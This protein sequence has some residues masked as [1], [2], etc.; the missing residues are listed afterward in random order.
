LFITLG[1][2]LLALRRPQQELVLAYPLLERQ[3]LAFQVLQV[4]V[5]ELVFPVLVRLALRRPQQELVL[6]Y[7]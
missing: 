7:P 5:L 6:A 3:E 4:L 1:L 2:G